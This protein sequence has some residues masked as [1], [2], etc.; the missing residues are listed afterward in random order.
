MSRSDK[1]NESNSFKHF[2]PRRISL[3]VDKSLIPAFSKLLQE[4]FSVEGDIGCSVKAFLCE[5]FGV[6]PDYL[7][8][9]I[10]TIFLNGS[11][12]DDIEKAIVGDGATLSLSAALPGLAGAT[13]RRGGYYA[14]MRD[15]I[16]CREEQS[17]V[18]GKRGKV[19]MKLFNMP[20][21]ELGPA[22]LERGILVE[23]GK[24]QEVLAAR[25]GAFRRECKDAIADGKQVGIGQVLEMDWGRGDIFLQVKRI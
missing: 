15:Q 3:T 10:Q 20:L 24:F 8:K 22:I 5:Q 17:S 13:L 1:S 21:Q 6:S 14:A 12:V 16:S 9:R 19:L 11:P 2:S 7:E 23:G 4:G 18:S 25:A